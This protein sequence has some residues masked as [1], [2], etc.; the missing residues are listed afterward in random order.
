VSWVNTALL[1]G[2][3]ID[4]IGQRFSALEKV[5]TALSSSKSAKIACCAHRRGVQKTAQNAQWGS[6]G[7]TPAR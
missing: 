1:Q 2:T 3:S 6:K 4:Q 7:S 5:K